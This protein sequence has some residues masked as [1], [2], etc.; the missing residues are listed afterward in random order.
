MKRLDYVGLV[1]RIN[2]SKDI[3]LETLEI[4]N[5]LAQKEMI[6]GILPPKKKRKRT[7][8]EDQQNARIL[9]TDKR[10]GELEEYILKRVKKNYSQNDNTPKTETVT[11]GKLKK[12]SSCRFFMT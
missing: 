10:L 9:N 6:R 3:C 2:E 7:V 4:K 1:D 8:F 11:I 12:T 5:E